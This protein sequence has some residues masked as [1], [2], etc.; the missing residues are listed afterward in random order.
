MSALGGCRGAGQMVIEA[1]TVLL[2]LS[3]NATLSMSNEYVVLKELR[4]LEQVIDDV[5]WESGGCPKDWHA[6]WT[7][8][9]AR[10]AGLYDLSHDAW[11][12]EFQYGLRPDGS[13][14]LFSCGPDRQPGTWD[15]LTAR[16]SLVEWTSARRRVGAKRWISGLGTALVVALAVCGLVR[17]IRRRH[18]PQGGCGR[19]RRTT[20]ARR[21]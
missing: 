20:E 19:G 12:T 14:Y 2:G 15:D 3:M 10:N 5:Q 11:E 18:G 1:T 6:V 21:H 16:T 8:E 9:A 4:R 17:H 13:H 7:S